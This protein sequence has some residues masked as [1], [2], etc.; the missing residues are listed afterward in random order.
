MI[1]PSQT[2]QDSEFTPWSWEAARERLSMAAGP[3]HAL[4]MRR[5]CVSQKHCPRPL[6]CSF[7]ILRG[8][9]RTAAHL[10][11]FTTE[12]GQMGLEGWRIEFWGSRKAERV[13]GCS[14]GGRESQS[15]SWDSP[16]TAHASV[17]WCSCP[18]FMPLATR[19]HSN[20]R[21]CQRS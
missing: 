2:T 4:E 17:H 9:T 20:E 6:S 1:D 7:P 21:H 14:R 13:F 8:S 19:S 3:D 16:L 15:L 18:Q 11:G 10:Y 5:V 12:Y